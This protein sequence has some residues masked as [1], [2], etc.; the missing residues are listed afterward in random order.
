[1]PPSSGPTQPDATRPALHSVIDTLRALLQRQSPADRA[2]MLDLIKTLTGVEELLTCIV[3]HGDEHPH[4]RQLYKDWRALFRQQ[5]REAGYRNLVQLEE[6]TGL[7][8]ATLHAMETGHR[9][10]TRDTMEVLLATAELD[11]DRQDLFVQIVL[12]R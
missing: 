12:N 5:R 6:R 7:S 2:V 9:P 10:P 4:F 11:L 3:R 8:A 1:M